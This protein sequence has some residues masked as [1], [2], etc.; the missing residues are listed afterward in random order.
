[1]ELHFCFC[2]LSLD[3][4]SAAQ[5]RGAAAVTP[6]AAAPIDL[7]GIWVSIVTQDWR[8]R[9]VTPAKGDCESVPITLEAKNVGDAWDPA[10]DEAAG[11][12]CRAYQPWVTAL[13][14]KKEPNGAKWDPTACSAR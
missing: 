6:K 8:W 13:H 3:F 7:T 5:G 14:F 12:Q 9:K 1:M 2:L 10:K 4:A 11:E